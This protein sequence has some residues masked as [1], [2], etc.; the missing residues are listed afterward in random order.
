MKKNRILATVVVVAAFALASCGEGGSEPAEAE[1]YGTP[2]QIKIGFTESGAPSAQ[3]G[4][5]LEHTN[6]DDIWGL[7][8]KVTPFGASSEMVSA[9]A[10]DAIDVAFV[11][12][13]PVGGAIARGQDFVAL[14][15][16][17]G[18]R[19]GLVVPDASD[20]QEIS[21]LSGK[22]VGVHEGSTSS[23]YARDILEQGGA[24]DV[25][26]V[27]VPLTEQ[28]A[29]LNSGGVDAVVGWSPTID[30]VKDGRTLFL[31]P[32]AVGNTYPGQ[33]IVVKRKFLEDHEEDLIRLMS[34][35]VHADWWASQNRD[36]SNAWYL[37]K[38]KIDPVLLEDML[39]SE[40]LWNVDSVEDVDF[41]VTEDHVEQMNNTVATFSEAQGIDAEVDWADHIDLG[42]YEE[43][44]Q[45]LKERFGDVEEDVKVAG[46]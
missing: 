4:Y 37:D 36:E 38:I 14:G 21:D 41:T 16:I 46:E 26:F 5:T 18:F 3:L 25:E 44:I 39:S 6:I 12:D 28:S 22:R 9:V 13:G 45:R 1:A 10:S 2:E 35:T 24:S 27:N 20:V 17:V 23:I 29:V 11:S 19:Q 31:E 43:G 33:F 42:P 15:E 34:A 32:A 30:L 8:V 40:P 7:D